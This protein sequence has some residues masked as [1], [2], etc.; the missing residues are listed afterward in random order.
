MHC[1]R[2]LLAIP[3]DLLILANNSYL[4]RTRAALVKHVSQELLDQS[5]SQFHANNPL[6]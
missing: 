2:F 3:W 4:G 1:T 5:P 6:S